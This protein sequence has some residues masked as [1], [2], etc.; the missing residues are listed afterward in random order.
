VFSKSA[1]WLLLAACSTAAP[2]A[3][4]EAINLLRIAQ[5]KMDGAHPNAAIVDLDRAVELNPDLT[6]ARYLRGLARLELGD[7]RR[8]ML[9]FDG[10]ARLDPGFPQ[11][12][13][14]RGIARERLGDWLG[15]IEDYTRGLEVDPD[16]DTARFQRGLAHYAL[17]MWEKAHADLLRARQDE[18][19]LYRWLVAARRGQ[20]E[21]ADRELAPTAQTRDPG[22]WLSYVA[23]YLIGSLDE[24]K[25]LSAASDPELVCSAFFFAGS[26]RLVDGDRERARELFERARS[27]GGPNSPE[28]ALALAE[29]GRMS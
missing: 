1:P 28:H 21:A 6:E 15:A 19:R 17:G 3:Q 7:P 24:E 20:R 25:F 12:L 22:E 26:K 10:V 9:D 23:A 13:V 8:A 14:A 16:D 11:V 29:L 5:M 4:R 27:A 18:S 2:G